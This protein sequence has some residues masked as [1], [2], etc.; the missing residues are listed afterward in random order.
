MNQDGL[1]DLLQ[2]VIAPPVKKFRGRTKTNREYEV[3][4]LIALGQIN[5]EIADELQ[6]S[7]KTV[8]K[9]REN[10]M[11]RFKLR[12]TADITRFAV[13]T[14]IIKVSPRKLPKI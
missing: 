12:N 11:K 3:V 13:A 14:K 2:A 5:K 8:E 10:I 9:H 1:I 6:I 4:R 7:I